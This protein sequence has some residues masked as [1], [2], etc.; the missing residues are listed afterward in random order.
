MDLKDYCSQRWPQLYEFSHYFNE[1]VNEL[2]GSTEGAIG[3]FLSNSSP[4]HVERVLNELEE[5][6]VF[7]REYL[8]K[9]PEANDDYLYDSMAFNYIP[10]AEGY[11]A[12]GWLEH[13]RERFRDY[14]ARTQGQGQ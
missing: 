9:H 11:T 5:Y 10:S 12:I 2:F 7:S 6:L 3:A 4:E 8:S 13:V 1:D 14:L